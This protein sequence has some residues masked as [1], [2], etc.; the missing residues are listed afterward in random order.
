MAGKIVANV[1]TD[2]SLGKS[3]L[4]SMPKGVKVLPVIMNGIPPAWAV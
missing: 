1:F 4:E 3:G 2:A